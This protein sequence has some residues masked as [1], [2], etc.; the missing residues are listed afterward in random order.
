MKNELYHH[1]IKGQRWGVR[2]YQNS[3]G[4]LTDDGRNRNKY[5]KRVLRAGKT[6]NDVEEILKT[7]SEDERKKLALDPKSKDNQGYLR[8]EDGASVAKRCLKKVGN[9]PV[10]FFDL[11]EDGNNLNAIIATKNDVN[12][13]GKG[14]AKQVA[15]LGMD[16]YNRNADK[17]EKVVWGVRADNT[18]SI[19]IAKDLGFKKEKGSESDGWVNYTYSKKS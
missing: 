17:Y 10:A 9:E 15:K 5:R 14:Y 2:R 4:S 11:L 1:G 6:R 7:M 16:W 12:Y 13:R 19:K 3:D 18:G 8:Y